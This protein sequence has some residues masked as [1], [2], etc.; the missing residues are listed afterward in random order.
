[1]SDWL[2]DL[3]ELSDDKTFVFLAFTSAMCI[4][5][6]TLISP[7]IPAIAEGVNVSE[8]EIGLII[9][10]F[11]LP[12]IFILPFSAYLSDNFGRNNVMSLGCLLIGFGGI[13]AFFAS[14]LNTLLISR[15]IQG[16]GMAGVMPLTVAVIGDLYTG[17]KEAAAQGLR[18]TSNKIGSILWSVVGGFLVAF[19]WN[20][21]FLIYAVFIPLGIVAYFKA[22]SNVGEN[23][24][25]LE[26]VKDM[27]SAVKKPK[28]A[29]YL[30]LGFARMF[31]KYAVITYVPILLTQRYGLTAATIGFFMAIRGIGGMS[32]SSLAGLIDEKVGKTRAIVTAFLSM[33]AL[34]ITVA[35]T[36]SM[37]IVVG[38][39]LLYGLMDSLFSSLHKS[40]LNHNISDSRRT[41]LINANSLMQNAGAT[42]APVV[43]GSILFINSEIWLYM[44]TAVSALAAT[45]FL[46]VQ[47][48]PDY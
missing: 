20:S 2:S 10:A 3:K 12:S 19:G 9:T 30:S 8:S 29:A 31:N 25:P 15:I 22:P 43:V 47:K 16:A 40:L 42:L 45:L 14:D 5:G 24:K 18:A 39:L 6:V 48:N 26:Y 35:L 36:D 4:T 33:G 17:P 1:M 13:A 41:G 38:M 44:I 28:I 32:S 21:V 46:F 37:W 27:S 11:T 23:R 34:T 7:A